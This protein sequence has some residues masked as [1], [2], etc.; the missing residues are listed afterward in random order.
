[1]LKPKDWLVSKYKEVN[2]IALR[3]PLQ[4]ELCV[5]YVLLRYK[6]LQTHLTLHFQS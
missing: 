5:L 1:M 4:Y 2:Y 3:I 6:A